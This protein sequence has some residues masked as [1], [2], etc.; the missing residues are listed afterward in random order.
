MD[1][2]LGAVLAGGASRRMGRDKALMEHEGRTLLAR[3]VAVLEA[4]LSEVI[5]VGPQRQYPSALEVP[6]VRDIRPGL[7]PVGGIHTALSHAKGRAVFVL[8]CDMPF[9]TADLVRWIAGP[10]TLGRNLSPDSA[11][12]DEPIARVVRDR[13]GAQALCGLYSWACLPVVEQAL[14]QGRLSAQD[15]LTHLETDYLELDREVDWYRPGLLTNINSPQ[16]LAEVRERQG[17]DS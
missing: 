10:M 13:H 9:V 5:V 15:L 4:V 1:H 16:D 3:A 12:V 14:N 6:S 17:R 2:V 11:Q 7:G 8:A